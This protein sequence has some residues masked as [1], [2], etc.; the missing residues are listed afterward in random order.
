VLL[1]ALPPVPLSAGGGG[2]GVLLRRWLVTD[3]L[4]SGVL[5]LDQDGNRVRH[6]VFAPFGAVAQEVAS[7]GS[8]PSHMF[9]GHRRGAVSGFHYMQARWQDPSTG[10][11]ISVDPLVPR[12]DDPQS[13]V[14]YAY[15]RNSPLMLVDPDGRTPIYPPIWHVAEA[16]GFDPA[17]VTWHAVLR[18]EHRIINEAAKE[19]LERIER[20]ES[21]FAWLK[22]GY[23]VFESLSSA[24]PSPPVRKGAERMVLWVIGEVAAEGGSKSLMDM[25]IDR[26]A[27]LD[28]LRE[29]HQRES[30][31]EEEFKKELTL[32]VQVTE[33]SNPGD[34][35]TGAS[36]N[37]VPDLSGIPVD[38]FSGV[39]WI[40]ISPPPSGTV[41]I[42]CI[43]GSPC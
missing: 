24:P 25:L 23:M 5:W 10:T 16:A 33:G 42:Y 38:A 31:R 34:A 37:G 20:L 9:A 18:A 2:G 4:G 30:M 6:T 39:Q 26:H 11:F 22:W 32:E 21:E 17:V 19:R 1:I 43:G 14:A 35:M 29:E 8:Q 41:T 13:Y 7:G 12:I 28:R 40:R 36:S 15:A 27:E 3:H